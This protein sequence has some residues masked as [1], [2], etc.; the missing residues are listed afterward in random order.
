MRHD[1]DRQTNQKNIFWNYL[2]M[3]NARHQQSSHCFCFSFVLSW[4]AF[5]VIEVKTIRIAVR[6]QGYI[7]TTRTGN[8]IH[9]AHS[10]TFQQLIWCEHQNIP[11]AN[12]LCLKTIEKTL[13]SLI[14]FAVQQSTLSASCC[15]T[16]NTRK[17]KANKKIMLELKISGVLAVR[18]CVVIQWELYKMNS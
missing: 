10:L 13:Q 12:V 3:R 17:S 5:Y 2:C 14:V 16:K 4:L 18:M 8:K 9:L 1:N 6:R 7:C 11:G 15:L